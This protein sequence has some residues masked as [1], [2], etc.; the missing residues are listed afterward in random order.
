MIWSLQV[1]RFVA[2]LMVVFLHAV[3]SAAR[4]SA[5]GVIPY[6]FEL[7]GS[8]GVDIFF[9]ISGVIMAT[10]APGRTPAEF[11]RARLLRIVPIY[12]LCSIP[13]IPIAAMG[14]GFGW[15]NILATVF[16]WPATDRMVAPALGA[17]WTLCFEM[18]FYAAVAL[19]LLDRRWLYALLA[20][21][22][23]AFLLRRVG[24]VFQFLGNPIIVEFMAGVV[25]ARI[26]KVRWGIAMLPLGVCALFLA[27]WLM[28]IPNGYNELFLTGEQNIQRVAVLGIPAILIVYGTMHIQVRRSVWTYLGGASYSLY[29]VHP[30][31]LSGLAVIWVLYPVG[32]N[33]IVTIGIVASLVV[34]LRV[35]ERIEKP[36]MARIK[37]AIPPAAASVE[38]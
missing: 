7:I 36:M 14:P 25:I 19:L 23:G 2:A 1:L 31:L 26:G 37:R 34:S 22:A 17:A 21:F 32:P 18:L 28:V 27:A 24:P 3:Q 8:A 20:I 11:I 6:E 38:A 29:L 9:V 30:I 35:Y 15:R 10:V 5:V 4:I 13:A 16:L 33:V 12:L